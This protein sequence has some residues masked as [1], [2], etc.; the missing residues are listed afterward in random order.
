[1][2]LTGP[3]NDYLQSPQMQMMFHVLQIMHDNPSYD[4]PEAQQQYMQNMG[5]GPGPPT[6]GPNDGPP[7]PGPGPGPAPGPDGE[8]PTYMMYSDDGPG[9]YFG[10]R[11]KKVVKKKKVSAALKRLCKKH[12]VRLTVKRGK[13]RVYKSEKVLKKQCKNA[14]KKKK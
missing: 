9:Y 6:L 13:E 8:P 12:K 2:N 5:L 1:M 4:F 7:G 3:P 11:K 10:K 14:M